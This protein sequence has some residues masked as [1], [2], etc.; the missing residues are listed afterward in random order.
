MLRSKQQ[1][2]NGDR[3]NALLATWIVRSNLEKRT[4]IH[5]I[6]N[7]NSNMPFDSC[8]FGCC[9]TFIAGMFS[10][11]AIVFFFFGLLFASDISVINWNSLLERARCIFILLKQKRARKKGTRLN[12]SFSILHKTQWKKKGQTIERHQHIYEYYGRI[13]SELLLYAH[14]HCRCRNRV[15]QFL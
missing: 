7:R 13:K 15:Q 8:D 2:K 5:M 1:K 10:C 11:L 12:V 3:K 9:S 4:H 14:E 6:S